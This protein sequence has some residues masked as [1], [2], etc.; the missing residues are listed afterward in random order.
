[1]RAMADG[2][3]DD[4]AWGAGTAPTGG[5]GYPLV[6]GESARGRTFIVSAYDV[7]PWALSMVGGAVRA[8]S[9]GKLT[10]AARQK[11]GDG[12]GSLRSRPYQDFRKLPVAGA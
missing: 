11:Q 5:S 8:S 4:A 12:R 6:F 3:G 7:Q 1:M 2:R 10:G 9:R